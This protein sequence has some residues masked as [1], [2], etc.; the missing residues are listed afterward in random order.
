MVSRY[1]P[2]YQLVVDQLNGDPES[3]SVLDKMVVIDPLVQ[4]G[5]KISENGVLFGMSDEP[6]SRGH[7]FSPDQNPSD[8]HANLADISSSGVK[9]VYLLSDFLPQRGYINTQ[10]SKK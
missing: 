4:T 9:V 10:V 6:Q 5:Q 1:G 7:L 2:Y 3:L 8:F